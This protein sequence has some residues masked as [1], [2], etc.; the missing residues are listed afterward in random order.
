MFFQHS[1]SMTATEN[2]KL[3]PQTDPIVPGPG[4]YNTAKGPGSSSTDTKGA[5]QTAA[6]Q[7]NTLLPYQR[8]P[9]FDEPGP[10]AYDPQTTAR[11]RSGLRGNVP[12]GSSTDREG[13]TGGFVEIL[14][15]TTCLYIRV[16]CFLCENQKK[17]VPKT[18]FWSD[19]SRPRAEGIF[20]EG[21]LAL[22]PGLMWTG[23]EA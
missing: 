12:F 6:F 15:G 10:G 23:I 14:P 3:H 22:L 7:S 21:I 16:S 4:E 5:T 9:D 17:I 19:P 11:M 8:V 2:L 13:L 1:L 18:I 20:A